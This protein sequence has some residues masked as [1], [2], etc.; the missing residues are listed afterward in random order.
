[1]VTVNLI[2]ST[3]FEVI[4]ERTT[5]TTHKVTLT[6]PYYEKLTGNR[7]PPEVLVEKSFRES[8]TSILRSFDLPVIGQY[9]PEYE[10]VIKGMLD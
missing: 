7:V 10:R 2:D 6:A 4:V 5:T 1:M 3:T 8:N 9:F